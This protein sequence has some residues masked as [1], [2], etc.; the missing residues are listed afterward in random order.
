[1]VEGFVIGV[2]SSFAAIAVWE[3]LVHLRRRARRRTD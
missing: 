2:T 1:L 3:A